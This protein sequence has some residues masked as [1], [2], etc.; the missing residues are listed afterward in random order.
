MFTKL[1]SQLKAKSELILIKFLTIFKMYEKTI[2]FKGFS[3]CSK[4]TGLFGV[5]VD[6][7]NFLQHEPVHEK[8]IMFRIGDHPN[9]F[10]KFTNVIKEFDQPRR[11]PRCCLLAE[12]ISNKYE[13]RTSSISLDAEEP[14]I[15]MARA[16]CPRGYD[17]SPSPSQ[18]E[19]ESQSLISRQTD[20]F[21]ETESDV[22]MAGEEEQEYQNVAQRGSNV[23]QAP[24][25]W[26]LRG[27]QPPNWIHPFM[28][29]A[30]GPSGYN[31]SSSPSLHEFDEKIESKPEARTA[32]TPEPEDDEMDGSSIPCR[33]SQQQQQ[34]VKDRQK[35]VTAETLAN[36]NST[37]KS[38][39]SKPRRSNRSRKASKSKKLKNSF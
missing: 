22:N 3:A 15:V 9:D 29:R 7:E 35:S 24:V 37:N 23:S 25:L 2:H 6:P 38:T 13:Y 12:V 21:T 4:C 32:H 19:R 18:Q 1:F 10:E 33:I 34:I 14:N 5:W 11:V 20:D 31:F 30:E 27:Q 8:R 26:E 28:G 16:E 39:T 17:F 36:K